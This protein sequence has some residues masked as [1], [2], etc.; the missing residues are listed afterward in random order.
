MSFLQLFRDLISKV[1]KVH[2][3]NQTAALSLNQL[4]VN[5]IV[6]EINYD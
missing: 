5:K 2:I 4:A 6:V 3:T 1:A